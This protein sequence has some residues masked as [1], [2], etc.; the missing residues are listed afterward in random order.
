MT[1]DMTDPPDSEEILKELGP[2]LPPIYGALEAGTQEAREY[3]ESRETPIDPY[4]A[5]DLARW[6]AK[7]YLDTVGHGISAVEYER[8][9]LAN[10]GLCVTYKN[11][12]L[13]RIRKSA[14]G[15]LPVPGRSK[16]MQYFYKQL[17]FGFFQGAEQDHQPGLL[18]LIILW[19]ATNNY[20]LKDLVLSC[21]KDGEDTRASVEAHWYIP[22]PH[23]A[24]SVDGQQS[25]DVPD[26]L[27]IS[28]DEPEEDTGTAPAS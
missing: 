14:N 7:Q 20:T 17:S 11:K 22:I 19:D 25:A 26:D 4:L 2:V 9:E 18:N 5:S 8:E 21:P 23:P 1:M 16:A 10:N 3:F 15:L 6:R 13:V 28:L 12:Y 27:D 24:L